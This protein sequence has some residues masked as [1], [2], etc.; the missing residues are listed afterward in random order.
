MRVQ[1]FVA[2]GIMGLALLVSGVLPAA[3]DSATRVT[4]RYQSNSSVGTLVV[5]SE[6]PMSSSLNARA[7]PHGH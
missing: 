3:G 5:V 6:S 4:W 2:T 1:A 7:L